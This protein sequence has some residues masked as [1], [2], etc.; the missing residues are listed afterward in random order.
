M[1]REVS[2]VNLA[3]LKD[4]I[5]E[6]LATYE[7]VTGWDLT[8]DR[9]RAARLELTPDKPNSARS[10]T[11][12]LFRGEAI[13]KLFVIAFK[14][15]DGTGDESGYNLPDLTDESGQNAT[16]RIPRN[17]TGVHAEA[18]LSVVSQQIDTPNS[19]PE[20]FA[21]TFDL[22]GLNG[23]TITKIGELG[24]EIDTPADRLIP[25]ATMTTGF[26]PM[27]ERFGDPHAVYSAVPDA[28]QVCAFLAITDL[29]PDFMTSLH[30][31]E[32]RWV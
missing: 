23:T 12:A 32:P 3:N 6:A 31:Q 1:K 14:P 21:G 4:P 2:G 16:K 11:D 28:V 19:S 7:N 15:E 13:G 9:E 24:P 22:L 20:L 17:K 27:G 25:T 30:A 26:N 8:L 18:H 29:H 10:A 5:I